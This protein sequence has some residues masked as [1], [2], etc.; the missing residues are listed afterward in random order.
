MDL[1]TRQLGDIVPA[2]Y[3][4]TLDRMNQP[5]RWDVA[6]MIAD[7]AERLRTGDECVREGDLLAAIDWMVFRLKECRSVLVAADSELS[8]VSHGRPVDR[9]ESG[10]VSSNARKLCDVLQDF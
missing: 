9:D 6:G 5:G 1:N 7:M 2:G 3:S 8:A 10:R 4:E